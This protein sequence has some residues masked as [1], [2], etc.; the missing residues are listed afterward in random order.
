MIEGLSQ[1]NPH[2][3]RFIYLKQRLVITTSCVVLRHLRSVQFYTKCQGPSLIMKSAMDLKLYIL[4]TLSKILA[5]LYPI[6]AFAWCHS[7][8]YL[9]I[10]YC[11][12]FSAPYALQIF[13]I[14]LFQRLQEFRGLK[15]FSSPLQQVVPKKLGLLLYHILAQPVFLFSPIFLL[16]QINN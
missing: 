15:I 16:I 11:Q 4:L 2:L 10:T 3:L 12:H 14:Q 13:Y 8:M 1:C 6:L 9:H 7:Y 5:N